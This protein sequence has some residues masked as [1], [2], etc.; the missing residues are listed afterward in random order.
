MKIGLIAGG[1]DLPRHV[2]RGALAQSHEVFIIALEGFFQTEDF[3]QAGAAG[4]ARFSY[5][6]FGKVVKR[7]KQENC[8]HICLA[9]QVSRP[10]FMRL[11]PDFQTLKRLPAALKAAQNGDDGLLSYI[12]S[13]FEEE[14]FGI[15]PPQDLCRAL[16][17]P[18]GHLGSVRI[19]ASM[20]E[21]AQKAC[22]IARQM[23]AHDIGQGA[24]ICRGLVLAVEA[25]EG[26]D[27]M[28]RRV[29]RLPEN[30]RGTP[31][32]RAG[33][34]AKMVKPDQESR[35]DLPTIGPKTAELA[36][37]AGLAGIVVESD[38]AFV[39]DKERVIEIANKEGLFI[40]G[41]PP[42]TR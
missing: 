9:G 41:L 8:T 36:S 6:E 25:Q 26:T 42:Q 34:L 32:A 21:D 10:N 38:G 35:V 4:I 1:G 24:I 23:G 7:L 27:E 14:G 31:K 5:G 3:I 30:I 29:G 40:A 28:L 37:A 15:I 2:M 12:V 33:I 22:Y 16:L 11:K 20:R 39:I 17:M 19:E 18:S 13:I